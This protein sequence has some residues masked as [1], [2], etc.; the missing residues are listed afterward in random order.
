MQAGATTTLAPSGT[1]WIPSLSCPQLF[2]RGK[3]LATKFRC[4]VV[5]D[6]M[7]YW[8][9]ALRP[10]DWSSIRWMQFAPPPEGL[11]PLLKNFLPSLRSSLIPVTFEA[12][13]FPA[14]LDS[15]DV[16][17]VSSTDDMMRKIL[18][19]EHKVPTLCMPSKPGESLRHKTLAPQ[20]FRLHRMHRRMLGG[21]TNG[22]LSLGFRGVSF[23]TFKPPLRR[24]VKHVLDFRIR[25]VTCV[26]KPSF[27][28]HASSDILRM[29]ELT[30]PVVYKS[31]HFC[32]TGWGARKLDLPELA[33]AFDLPSQSIPILTDSGMLVSFFPLK[34]VTEPLQFLLNSLASQ[35]MALLPQLTPRLPQTAPAV[36]S[37]LESSLADHFSQLSAKFTKGTALVPL[38][39]EG[40]PNPAGP[41]VPGERLW[42]RDPPDM[43]WLPGLGKFCLTLGAT[44]RKSRTRLWTRSSS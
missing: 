13:L 44:T 36:S 11:S 28:H 2:V 1:P 21:V 31:P 34:L 42:S 33:C 23:A 12:L 9:L 7:P 29:A 5:S 37:P 19:F 35:P 15:V 20:G 40:I 10:M 25:P 17:L 30:L 18:A 16:L 6:G 8:L 27:S 14:L 32:R 3:A 26:E 43:T 38:L 41:G 22:N 4:L 24:T 39:L